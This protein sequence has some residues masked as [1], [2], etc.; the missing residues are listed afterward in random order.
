MGQNHVRIFDLLHVIGWDDDG[1]IKQ[2]FHFSS[3]APGQAEGG[4]P[5]STGKLEGA[6]NVGGVA[7][8]ADAKGNVAGLNKIFHLGGKNVGVV[9]VIRPGRQHRDVIHHRVGPQAFHLRQGEGTRNVSPFAQIGNQVGGQSGAAT[10]SESKDGVVRFIGAKKAINGA[11][12]F[13]Q[14]KTVENSF[15]G[16][17]VS[18]IIKFSQ[19]VFL[20]A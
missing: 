6:K 9:G 16:F 14:G 18:G 12:R 4:G 20:F 8:A 13:R 2:S 1:T 19:L 10:I 7:A 15:Q 3:A 11:A 17:K 5:D